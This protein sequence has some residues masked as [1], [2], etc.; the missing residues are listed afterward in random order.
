MG[1]P[2]PITG[3]AQPSGGVGRD[4]DTEIF[5]RAGVSVERDCM[6]AEHHKASAGFVQLDEQV[7]KIVEQLNHARV[8]GTK[9]TG[10]SRRA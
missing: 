1:A 4:Q 3:I 7:T 10:R 2:R 8:R 6:P 9:R 5:G